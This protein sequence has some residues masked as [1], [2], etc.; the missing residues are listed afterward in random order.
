MRRCGSSCRGTSCRRRRR[1]C[2]GSG[3]GPASSA[4]G[5]WGTTGRARL[6][7]RGTGF[8]GVRLHEVPLVAVE[9]EEHGDRAVPLPPR[10]LGE[11][12]AARRHVVV[13]A[14][15]VVGLEEEEDPSAGLV[16]DAALLF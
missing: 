16:A 1:R 2:W 3:P 11:P 8:G 9:V 14:P 10:L 12:N 7:G 6:R 15:E 4:A 13:V 5:R